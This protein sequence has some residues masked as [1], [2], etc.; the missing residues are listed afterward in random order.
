MSAEYEEME[1]EMIGEWESMYQNDIEAAEEALA[2]MEAEKSSGDVAVIDSSY[3]KGEEINK[4]PSTAAACTVESNELEYQQSQRRLLLRSTNDDMVHVESEPN[5]RPNATERSDNSRTYLHTRPDPENLGFTCTLSSGERF[6][7]RKAQFLG[8]SP[9]PNGITE[10]LDVSV[11][12]LLQRIEKV[13]RSIDM[14]FR[15]LLHC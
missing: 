8:R 10:L 4:G 7:L 14:R 2:E 9:R 5:A 11:A 3:Q 12:T 13:R 15:L 1:L 6:F